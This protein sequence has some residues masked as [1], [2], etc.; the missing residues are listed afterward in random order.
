MKTVNKFLMICGLI[1]FLVTIQTSGYTQT[2]RTF[3][4]LFKKQNNDIEVN[5]FMK[6]KCSNNTSTFKISPKIKKP[7]FDQTSN[8]FN[9][10]LVICPLTIKNK[11]L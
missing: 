10:C 2:K 1:V 4:K 5:W 9:V 6:V 7:E 3:N 11:K 8:R